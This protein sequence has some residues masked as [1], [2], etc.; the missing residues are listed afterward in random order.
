M[1]YGECWQL[2]EN[3]VT[4]DTF[5]WSNIVLG[6]LGCTSSSNSIYLATNVHLLYHVAENCICE[7]S[8]NK[9]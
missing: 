6:T 2:L 3:L 5:L 1:F 7:V 9:L 8:P 4:L